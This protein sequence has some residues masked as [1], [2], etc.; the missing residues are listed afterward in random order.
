MRIIEGP[1][2]VTHIFGRV[3]ARQGPALVFQPGWMGGGCDA[4]FLLELATGLNSSAGKDGKTVLFKRFVFAG[5][6]FSLMK[7]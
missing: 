2:H 6:S 3:D 5:S 1:H 4:L 7:M